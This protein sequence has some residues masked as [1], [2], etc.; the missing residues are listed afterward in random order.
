MVK[1]CLRNQESRLW[2]FSDEQPSLV[3]KRMLNQDTGGLRD[4]R[5]VLPLFHRIAVFKIKGFHRQ[6]NPLL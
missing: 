1:R 3:A 5:I 2:H 6:G 4:W